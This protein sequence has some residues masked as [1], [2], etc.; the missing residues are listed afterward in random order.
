[1]SRPAVKLA[2]RD[3]QKA[4]E[5]AHEALRDVARALGSAHPDIPADELLGLSQRLQRALVWHARVRRLAANL[6]DRAE[7][8]GRGTPW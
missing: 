8:G 7:H 5:K 2:L 3:A 4:L 1:M 6:L